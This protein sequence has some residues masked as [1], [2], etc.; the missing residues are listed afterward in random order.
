MPLACFLQ[1]I[2]PHRQT[3]YLIDPAAFKRGAIAKPK[4]AEQSFSTSRL[5]T[6]ARAII[7][8]RQRF[9]RIRHQPLMG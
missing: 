8:G 2:T 7:P 6:S 9:A 3:Y 5:A 1:V 4:S